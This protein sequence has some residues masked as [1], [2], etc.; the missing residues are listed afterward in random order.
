M[1][2]RRRLIHGL[3]ASTASLSVSPLIRSIAAR[4]AGWDREAPKRFVFVVKASGVDKFNLVPPGIENHFVHETTSEKLGNRSRRLGGLI[5]VP[6]AKCGL[7]DK[8]AALE[9]L[10]N[11]VTILQSLSGEGFTGNHTSGYGALSCHNSET[12]A[13]A[14][15]VDCM[16]GRHL[17][18]G[19]YPMYGMALSGRLLEHGGWKPE[20]TYCYPNISAY[21]HGMP[22]AYQASPR[23]AF[24]DLFGSAVATP[25]EL[26]RKLSLNGNLMDFL[27]EDARRV[28]R[29]LS[30]EEMER[31]ARYTESFESLKLIEEKKAHLAESIKQHAPELSKRYDS[32]VPSVRIETHFELA[33]AALIA[34]LTNVITLRPDT[35]GAMYSGLRLSESV[36]AIGHLQD[37][38]A[39][40]GWSGHQ[41]REEIEKVHL[42]CIAAMAKK[43]QDTP[44]GEGTMLDNTL[45][46]YM[47]CNGGDHH[48]GQADWPFVLVGGMAGK[49]KMGRYIE[50]P[51]Y[52]EKGHRTIGNLYLSLMQAAGMQTPE[53][54]GQLDANLKDCDVTGPLTEILSS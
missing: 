44:E 8:L 20:D 46:V 9:E 22:V 41:A 21:K 48:G 51:K 14:P 2:T 16:L 42:K 40:N 7:P 25:E 43:L 6:F 1:L 53:T 31:F 47:S 13:I 38:S 37:S 36:H 4:A 23:K 35:L 45:I 26:K 32:V 30:A 15:T 5:D 27:K 54:F 19:P 3:S 11:R 28:E 12:V 24:L 39:G 52:Q 50:Y 34:G 17:S 18:S 49:L 33:T 10:K 29:Q